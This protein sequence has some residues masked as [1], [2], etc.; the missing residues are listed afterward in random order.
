M[1]GSDNEGE[2]RVYVRAKE[3]IKEQP[4]SRNLLAT[5]TRVLQCTSSSEIFF[6]CQCSVFGI[7]INV[8]F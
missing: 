5:A 3:D 8:L 1:E 2:V 6:S 7:K 4:T